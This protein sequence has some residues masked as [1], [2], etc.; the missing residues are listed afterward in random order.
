MLGQNKS[1]ILF[2]IL[3]FTVFCL[4][5]AM[6]ADVSINQ[7]PEVLVENTFQTT[8]THRSEIK[9]KPKKKKAKPKKKKAKPKKKNKPK[10]RNRR[11]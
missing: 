8:D 3:I 1:L 10:N 7:G 5:T 4:Q 6:Q 2:T 9:K 11:R